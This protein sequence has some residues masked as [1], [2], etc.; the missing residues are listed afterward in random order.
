MEKIL[1]KEAL[2][3][4]LDSECDDY[5]LTYDYEWSEDCDCFEVEIGLDYDDTKK[6]HVN[7]KYNSDSNDLEIEISED[8]YHQTRWYNSSVK[9]FW[10][11]VASKLF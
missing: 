5:G 9:Y 10:M 2:I 11:K 7:F 8:S 4:Y 6:C 1:G 3:E